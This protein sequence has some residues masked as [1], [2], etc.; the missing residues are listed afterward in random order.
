MDPALRELWT[1]P[2]P[3]G[4]SRLRGISAPFEDFMCQRELLAE[5]ARQTSDDGDAGGGQSPRTQ[6]V[7]GAATAMELLSVASSGTEVRACFTCG[8]V[9]HL[10]RDCAKALCNYCGESGHTAR[11]CST[12]REGAGAS[13]DAVASLKYARSQRLAWVQFLGAKPERALMGSEGRDQINDP[14]KYSEALRKEFWVEM[15]RE[16]TAELLCRRGG[17]RHLIILCVHAHHRFQGPASI[18][19]VRCAFGNPPT[20]V[21]ALPCCSTFNPTKDIGRKPDEA[22]EDMAIFSACRKVLVWRWRAG[23]DPL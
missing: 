21:V 17:V 6:S 19:N 7:E 9:G 22:Y 3:H 10:T 1:G 15:R 2:N 8:A 14:A 11:D 18:K 23:P 5:I 13:I 12:K 4:V 20:T 16:G